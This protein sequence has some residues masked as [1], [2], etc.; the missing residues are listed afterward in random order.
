[1][2]ILAVVGSPRL[3]GNTNYLVDQALQEAIKLGAKTEKVVISQHRLSP[4]F[5]HTNCR[6]LDSCV[7]QDDGTRIL[8]KFC[9]ADGVILA[10]PVYYY[11]V[12]AWMKIFIDRNYFLGR[13]GKKSQAKAVGII[14][15]AGGAGIEDTVQTL[16]RF[17]GSSSFNNL[18]EDKRFF[19]TGYARGLGDVSSDQKLVREARDLGR[20]LVVSS[21]E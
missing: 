14:V 7:Q 15:V 5:A 9:K 3:N 13:H 10:T 4:C 20:Q 8:E 21:K 16:N 18:A 19:V 1:M 11:D 2:Y 12:S 17:V 6:E